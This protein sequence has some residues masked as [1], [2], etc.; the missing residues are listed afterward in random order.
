[1]GLLDPINPLGES[2]IDVLVCKDLCSRRPDPGT[3]RTEGRPPCTVVLDREDDVRFTRTALAAHSPAG[4]RI[5][6]HPTVASGDG[7]LW[8]DILQA[9]GT[10]HA[11]RASRE[12]EERAARTALK[13]ADPC[14]VTVL[15]AHRI[16]RGLWADLVH[17]HRTTVRIWFSCTTPTCRTPLRICC[18]TA[19]TGSS[20][21]SPG[22]RSCTRPQ[23]C[24]PIHDR[25]ERH[26]LHGHHRPPPGWSG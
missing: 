11:A 20:R 12:E 5:V 15:R 25:G 24:S 4:G 13:A 17:L 3:L 22:W 18:V 14:Q 21:P 2:G 26:R 16:G 7:L 8:H 9:L 1:M 10:R 23:P 19:I 6:V